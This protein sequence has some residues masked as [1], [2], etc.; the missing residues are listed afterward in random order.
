MWANDICRRMWA[1][2]GI[3]RVMWANDDIFRRMWANDD[4]YVGECG[5]MMIYMQVNVVIG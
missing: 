4:I 1:N 3:C 5:L 2:D